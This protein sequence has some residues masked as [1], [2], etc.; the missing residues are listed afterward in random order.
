MGVLQVSCCAVSGITNDE[1]SY[2]S[3]KNTGATIGS[4]SNDRSVRLHEQKQQ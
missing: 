3:K 4:D 1:V 2:E